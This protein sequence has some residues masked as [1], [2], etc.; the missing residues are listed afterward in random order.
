MNSLLFR[1]GS[2]SLLLGLGLSW[3]AVRGQTAPTS[4][5]IFVCFTKAQPDITVPCK[6]DT[7]IE[8]NYAP[9]VF[10]VLEI[11]QGT[12][13]AVF[14]IQWCARTAPELGC[15]NFSK[16]VEYEQPSGERPQPDVG[17]N[18]K[19]KIVVPYLPDFKRR[20]DGTID[21]HVNTGTSYITVSLHGEIVGLSEPIQI[22][23]K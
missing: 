19:W 5:D 18:A 16:E 14:T 1:V 15:R 13:K 4:P 23:E 3:S 10:I 9:K 12:A 17:G 22:E 7:S 6:G 8:V 2:L 20:T 21:V 11:P